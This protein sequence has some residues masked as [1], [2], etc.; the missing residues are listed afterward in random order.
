MIMH[1]HRSLAFPWRLWLV[2]IT[3]GLL[4][5]SLLWKGW[6]LTVVEHPALL[7][8]RE[9]Q[10]RVTLTVPAPRGEI[11]DRNGIPLAVSVFLTSV[12]ADPAYF[13]DLMQAAPVIAQALE[14]PLAQLQARLEAAQNRRFV[15]L[16]RYLSPE[17]VADLKARGIRGLHFLA[18]PKRFYPAAEVMATVLGFT[19]EHDR[20][21]EGL[22]RHFN[23]LLE[24][25]VGEKVF[26]RD[27][28]GRLT[29]AAEVERKP[30]PGSPLHLSIDYNVQ[31][32]LYQVMQETLQTTNAK[33][34]SA[35]ILDSRSAE[36][37]AMLTV[38]S[39][40]PNAR[41]RQFTDQMRNRIITDVFEPGSTMKPF[42]IIAGLQS[43]RYSASTI[44][45]ETRS[46]SYTL[47]KHTIRD[48]GHR[49]SVMNVKEILVRSS[50]VGSAV[51]GLRLDKKD[52]ARL[53]TGVGFGRQTGI[54]FPGE[55]A[56]V[57]PKAENWRQANQMTIAYGYGISVT[58]L[59]LAQA[60]AVIAN[61]GV[62]KP[63]TLLRREQDDPGTPVLDAAV[64]KEVRA[65]MEGVVTEGT[66]KRAQIEGYRIAGKT[67][68]AHKIQ[69]G[70]YVSK[71]LAFFA[72]MIP[73]SDP[74]LVMVVMVDEPSRGSHYG[75]Q[76]AAPL[77]KA[78]MEKILPALS[79]PP[80][81]PVAP[82][83][84]A[85]KSARRP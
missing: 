4:Y 82:P 33:A 46:S 12:W 79:I 39:F 71:Y 9:A 16:R 85:K 42:T 49:G 44:I 38:P 28:L 35:V 84:P 62:F 43:G 31:H 76:V 5:L 51:I 47:G 66:A 58:M 67:G 13:E 72:G 63:V 48:V 20:G 37:L 61:D 68:T 34:V 50:N 59:Q 64:V 15:Y 80:D 32:L 78:A 73:A 24:G 60:Y 56:G 29:E 55:S 23:A 83:P 22:E 69:N 26:A 41:Q 3:V 17:Q 40:N 36:V 1:L 53:L 81:A 2:V 8:K 6:Q 70:R 54:E 30:S 21:Q 74:R 27:R 14:M 11:F 77:F 10:S 7:A 45:P 65:M 75:G 57:L 25:K 19:G 18:E 52:F